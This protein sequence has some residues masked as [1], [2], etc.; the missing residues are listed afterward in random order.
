MCIKS[1]Q[2][3]QTIIS[4]GHLISCCSFCFADSENGC[5]G[6]YPSMG[7]LYWIISG[8]PTESC[9]SFKYEFHS[10]LK[11]IKCS[12]TCD[13]GSKPIY[14]YGSDY[15]LI[16]NDKKEIMYEIY[17]HGSITAYYETYE[18]FYTFWII[19]NC[20]GIY[21][22]TPGSKK[23]GAHIVKIIGWEKEIKYWLCANSCGNLGNIGGFF[24]IQRGENHVGIESNV[25]AGYLDS[26]LLFRSQ[27]SLVVFEDNFLILKI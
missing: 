25:F 14:Y 4:E 15:K 18:D 21:E 20:K 8:L 27:K 7:F 24:K 3:V 17:K 11:N 9:K 26:Y 13:D 23:K 16:D 22:L 2:E 5:Y 19:N 10:S 1:K 6:G 12:K